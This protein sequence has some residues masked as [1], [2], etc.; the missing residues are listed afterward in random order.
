MGAVPVRS[1]HFGTVVL[2]R[3]EVTG[4]ELWVSLPAVYRQCAVCYTDFWKAYPAVLPSKRHRGVGKERGETNHIER[5][6]NTF[7]QRVSRLV[8][9]TLS[10]SKRVANYIGAVWYYVHHHN[11]SLRA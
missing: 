11:A 5:L 7:C 8:C 10:F 2:Q 6:N 3:D 4:R 1:A 9:C